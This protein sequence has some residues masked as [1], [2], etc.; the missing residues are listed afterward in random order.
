MAAYN[1][2]VVQETK[3]GKPLLVTSSA[4]KARQ[5]LVGSGWRVEVW[6]DNQKVEIVHF[7]TR[8]QLEPYIEAEKDYIRQKQEKATKRRSLRYEQSGNSF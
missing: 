7:K 1:T 6:S 3:G 2:F 4:R 8:S 5:L